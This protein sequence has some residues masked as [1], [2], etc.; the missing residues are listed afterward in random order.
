MY[1]YVCERGVG[2]SLVS[3]NKDCITAESTRVWCWMRSDFHFGAYVCV[4]CRGRTPKVNSARAQGNGTG[5]QF[6]GALPNIKPARPQVNG[7]RPHVNRA[8]PKAN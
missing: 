7:T 3:K 1:A 4:R 5:H 8:R 6:N 2:L